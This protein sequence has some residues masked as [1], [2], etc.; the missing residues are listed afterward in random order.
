[1]P[2]MWKQWASVKTKGRIFRM[3]TRKELKAG[4]VK[5]YG[6]EPPSWFKKQSDGCSVEPFKTKRAVLK[7][8]AAIPNAMARFLLRADEARE[9]CY[10]HDFGYYVTELQWPRDSDEWVGDR[11]KADN[12][13]RRNRVLVARN[14]FVGWI[15]SRLYF[16]AVRL[17]GRASMKPLS[18]LVMPPTPE[19][20]EQLE[21][22]LR[23]PVTGQA[24][25]KL[26]AWKV[27]LESI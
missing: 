4:S 1:M 20:L 16:R 27:Q 12:R 13:L 7:Q 9:A 10:R 21:R 26:A 3:K 24:R 2:G 15:Y 11:M 17:R 22:Y 6:K 23:I 25:D 8:I 5:L 14:R 19:A 18:E